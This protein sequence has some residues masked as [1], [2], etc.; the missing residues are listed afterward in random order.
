MPTFFHVE[1]GYR[2]LLAANGLDSF[3][4]I[5][6]VQQGGRL[7]KPGLG[8]WRQRWRMELKRPDG[9]PQIVY[10]KR[11][12]SPPWRT[13]LRRWSE[14]WLGSGAALVEWSNALELQKCGVTAARPIAAGQRSIGLWERASFVLLEQVPGE[15]LET[16]AGRGQSPTHR[17]ITALASFV[18]RFH[19]AGFVHR[20]LY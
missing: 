11:F 8:S 12:V 5:M 6:S 1:S 7:D 9:Q 13:Q 16:L 3:D 10:L 18:A 14:G 19:A 4:A 15:S 17:S 2:E 20:D